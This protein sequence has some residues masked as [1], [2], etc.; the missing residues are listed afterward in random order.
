VEGHC[1][2]NK[3]VDTTKGLT[4]MYPEYGRREPLMEESGHEESEVSIRGV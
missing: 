4:R 2:P 3:D 1:N